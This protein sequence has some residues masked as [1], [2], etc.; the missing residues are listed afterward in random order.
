MKWQK[1]LDAY[2]FITALVISVL[3]GLL[4][5]WAIWWAR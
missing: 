3:Y 2:D 4:L 5:A 1:H